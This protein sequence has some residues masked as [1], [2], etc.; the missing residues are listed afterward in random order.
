[1]RLR[2]R[3]SA[4]DEGELIDSWLCV[5]CG[6]NTAPGLLSRLELET[7]VKTEKRGA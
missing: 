7:A 5:D 6:T 3:L 2:I 1:M 4:G